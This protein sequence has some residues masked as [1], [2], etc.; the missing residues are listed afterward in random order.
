MGK[1]LIVLDSMVATSQIVSRSSHG[2]FAKSLKVL[3]EFV[4]E[5]LR[6]LAVMNQLW[7]LMCGRVACLLD[8]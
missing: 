7:E 5:G 3:E 2:T 8:H 6:G 4:V 1:S